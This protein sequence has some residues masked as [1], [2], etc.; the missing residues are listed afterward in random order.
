MPPLSRLSFK[1]VNLYEL[2]ENI[3]ADCS[4]WIQMSQIVGC[5]FPSLLLWSLHI[6]KI[7][8]LCTVLLQEKKSSPKRCMS[9]PMGKQKRWEALISSCL[10]PDCLGCS[11][12]CILM[13]AF[14]FVSLLCPGNCKQ[15]LFSFR[16]SPSSPLFPPALLAGTCAGDW[17]I[18]SVCCSIAFWCTFSVLVNQGNKK[19]AIYNVENW[20]A[21]GR[22]V[23]TKKV[24]ALCRRLIIK[25]IVTVV[26]PHGILFGFSTK[27]W[28]FCWCLWWHRPS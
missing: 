6:L 27:Q 24:F 16:H 3:L 14:F 11:L 7:F 17:Q 10:S 23:G 13:F 15:L 9:E 5:I 18:G 2:L 12:V 8:S 21:F 20:V 25:R 28:L 22:K 4:M 26:V 1:K 19:M